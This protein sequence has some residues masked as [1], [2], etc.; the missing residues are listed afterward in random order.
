VA[1]LS[2]PRTRG[3]RQQ[4]PCIWVLRN[5]QY[6]PGDLR[7]LREP[8][9][10]DDEQNEDQ[11]RNGQNH[12]HAPVE[13][14]AVRPSAVD[15]WPISRTQGRTG[16]AQAGRSRSPGPLFPSTAIWNT[17]WMSARLVRRGHVD[18]R[19]VASALCRTS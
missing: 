3:V 6:R 7:C 11:L 14:S 9:R 10:D 18:L 16:L 15:V 17:D 5:I 19:R 2:S 1:R 12:I 4:L 8:D 13:Q